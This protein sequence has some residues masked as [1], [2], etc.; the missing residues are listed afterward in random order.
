MFLRE[1]PPM[2][3]MVL[4]LVVGYLASFVRFCCVFCGVLARAEHGGGLSDVAQTGTQA[5]GGLYDFSDV[6]F[7]GICSL[8]V[9][10][11]CALLGDNYRPGWPDFLMVL[12]VCFVGSS[13]DAEIWGLDTNEVV[14]FQDE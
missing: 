8:V 11:Y 4:V 2:W 3:L 5:F 7:H 10:L 1:I 12:V 13:G 14:S 6:F 9:Y